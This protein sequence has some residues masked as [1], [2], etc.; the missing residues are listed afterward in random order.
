MKLLIV[1]QTIDRED[2]VLGFFHRWVEEF[3]T[4]FEHIEVVCLKEGRHTLPKNVAVHSLGKERG[5]ASRITYS[6]RFLKLLWQLRFHYDA[7]FV[8]MN[9]EYVLL[10]GLYWKVVGRPVYMWRNHYAGSLLTDLAVAFCKKVFCTSKS[11]YTA[12]YKKTVLMPVGI[13]TE[14]FKPAGERKPNTI[15]SLG[16]IAPSKNIHT[17]LAALKKLHEDGV[18]FSASIYGGALPQDASYLEEQKQF[19][20]RE[21]LQEKVRFYSGVPHYQT[22][23][24]YSSH[25]IFVNA[26]RS[27]MFDKTILEAAACGC[28]PLAS[29]EDWREL[30]G[31]EY[32]FMTP[33][34]LQKKL[35]THLGTFSSTEGEKSSESVV[36]E[37]SLAALSAALQRHI[38][39]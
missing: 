7:V 9:Q 35:Q 36:P 19:V 26:S 37:H 30:V 25:D 4:R 12:K 20:E 11:S 8:H 29:S 22:P 24:I 34:D 6:V 13:D 38:T 31:E 5:A 15:L 27:G 14:V 3:A 28:V 18:E 23:A 21:G 32:F 1:T 33:K 10:G 39:R 2:P 17:I 16:R